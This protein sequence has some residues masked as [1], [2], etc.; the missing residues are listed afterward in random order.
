M[1]GVGAAAA[2]A[3][4]ATVTSCATTRPPGPLP[5]RAYKQIQTTSAL[6]EM[7]CFVPYVH[8]KMCSKEI[9]STP[10]IVDTVGT[11]S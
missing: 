1:T 7:F 11:L 6:T 5:C 3:G 10:F 8:S 9:Q 4:V 2:M